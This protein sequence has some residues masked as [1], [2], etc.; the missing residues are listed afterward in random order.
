MTVSRLLQGKEDQVLAGL[1]IGP[2]FLCANRG[3]RQKTAG[4]ATNRPKYDAVHGVAM[5]IE[6]G[7][8]VDIPSC[9]S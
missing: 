8:F 9:L 4:K 6:I 2:A 5:G 7:S 3:M 1:C